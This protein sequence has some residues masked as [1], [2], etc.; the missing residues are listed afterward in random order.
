MNLT[1]IESLLGSWEYFRGLDKVHL[2]AMAR[3]GKYSEAHSSDIVLVSENK[4]N[5]SL[6]V[7]IEGTLR[8]EIE[9][10]LIN[11]ID[12]PGDTAG[13]ISW[14]TGLRATASVVAEK[15]SRY[16][17]F[18]LKAIEAIDE[19]FNQ[20]IKDHFIRIFPLIISK[21]LVTTNAKAKAVTELIE[22]LRASEESLRLMNENLGYQ[23][24]RKE[25]ETFEQIH[26][27]AE[28]VL[29]K[30]LNYVDHN[31]KNSKA[32]SATQSLLEEF[33]AQL[34]RMKNLLSGLIV[35]RHEEDLAACVVGYHLEPREASALKTALSSFGLSDD[36]N[37]NERDD[38]ANQK[39]ILVAGNLDLSALENIKFDRKIAFLKSL[40]LAD[41]KGLAQFD[42]LISC[43]TDNRS[44]IIRTLTTG[45]NKV[46]FGNIWGLHKYLSWGTK[47]HQLKIAE[48][49][50]RL[51]VI[52]SVTARLR[53]ARMR[54]SILNQIHFVLEELL[55]NAI[56]DAPTDAH[57][58]SIYN[59][60]TRKQH[61]SLPDTKE[62]VVSYGT[63][64][65]TAGVAVTDPFGSITKE[66]ILSYLELGATGGDTS[67]PKKG[68][69]GKG[70]YLIVSNSS[71]T[72]FNVEKGLKTEI[73]C[74]FDL[75]K[76]SNE[77][78]NDSPSFH[79]YFC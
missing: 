43:P 39:R 40:N 69:A 26:D 52:N 67:D 60:I 75:E 9:G 12:Q 41:L 33:D 24:A 10:N 27:I 16:L 31:K 50:K 23:I 54:S 29:P 72:I 47:I 11:I 68:G 76:N 49:S 8:I 13:E 57:G 45:L 34:N 53:E 62:V 32:N 73:I 71:Q 37:L 19:E 17:S 77:S 35:G 36:Q 74:L 79:F 78:G 28:K 56:Y 44:A 18:S 2:E 63:D 51:E 55:M 25:R 1:A 58:N 15:S 4:E 38:K 3:I 5:D 61:V 65:I 70:L 20:A 14:V 6:T 59:H 21:R 22:K 7:L 46:I 48:S 66:V 64:G 42:T 30:L